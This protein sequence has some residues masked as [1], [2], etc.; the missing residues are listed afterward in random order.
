MCH[1]LPVARKENKLILTGR[2]KLPK[3]IPKNCYKIFIIYQSPIDIVTR[4]L[5]NEGFNDV[6]LNQSKL[7]NLSVKKVF[8][9][10]WE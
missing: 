2:H 8:V 7:N 5:C 6:I 3:G 10:S 1:F 4:P 9:S